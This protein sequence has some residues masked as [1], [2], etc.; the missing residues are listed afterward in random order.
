MSL[1]THH[2]LPILAMFGFVGDFGWRVCGCSFLDAAHLGHLEMQ[3]VLFVHMPEHH[4]A[5]RVVVE[6][7]KHLQMTANSGHFALGGPT[8]GRTWIF[9]QS[10]VRSA[11]AVGSNRY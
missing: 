5:R 9:R 6:G 2:Q 3:V 1:S 10:H 7:Q 8:L 11:T 4:L